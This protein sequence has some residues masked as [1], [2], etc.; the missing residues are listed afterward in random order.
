MD[1]IPKGISLFDYEHLNAEA[2]EEGTYYWGI[3][4]DD[5]RD[6][7][8]YAD[9][10][11]ASPNGDLIALSHV[12]DPET[13]SKLSPEIAF[14]SL[15]RGKWLSF[16]KTSRLH[17]QPISLHNAAPAGEEPCIDCN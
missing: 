17:G 13:R 11:D 3:T 14:M 16:W 9:R 12:R 15:A 4:L 5:G 2:K 1:L 8:I 10:L 7:Y 6:V